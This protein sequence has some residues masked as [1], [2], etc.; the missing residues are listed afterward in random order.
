[1][2]C[3]RQGKPSGILRLPSGALGSPSNDEPN[4][5]CLCNGPI[6]DGQ[7]K[8]LRQSKN[9]AGHGLQAHGHRTE[10]V[11]SAERLSLISR[12]HSGSEIQ[13]R[14]TSRSRR[15]AGSRTVGCTPD[16]TIAPGRA[17]RSALRLNFNV[18]GRMERFTGHFRRPATPRL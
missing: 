16:L 11:A 2:S 10:K 15:P 18:R 4:R 6:A 8:E 1:M 3:Q 9:D 17:V 5:V 12:R 14:R 7:D 13:G